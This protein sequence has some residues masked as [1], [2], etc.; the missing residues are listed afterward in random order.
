MRLTMILVLATLLVM[1]LGTANASF[2]F[3]Q[4]RKLFAG[5]TKRT[6]YSDW[7]ERLNCPWAVGR[8]IPQ[9]WCE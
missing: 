1:S 7:A 2:L 6:R 5:K 8:S 9:E 3:A 4:D